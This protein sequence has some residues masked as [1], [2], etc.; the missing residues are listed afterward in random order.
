MTRFAIIGPT[1]PYRGGIAHHTTLLAQALAEQHEVLL[2]SFSQQYP[3]WLFPG[4]SDRDPSQRPLQTN[5]HYLLDPIN[6]FTW[7]RT[8]RQV[9]AWQPEVLILPWWHPYFAPAWGILGRWLKRLPSRPKLLFVCHNILPHEQSRL[10]RWVLPPLVRWT[11]ACGDGFVLQSH[12]E[13]AVL[14]TLL[15][16]R[17]SR[18]TPLPT[19]ADIGESTAPELP[20]PLPTEQPLLLFA[21]LVRPYKGVD[22]LLEAMALVQEPCHLLVAGEFWQGTERFAAQIARLGLADKVTLWDEYLPN[23]LL[24]ACL[25]RAD[26]LVLPY[27]SATQSAIVQLAFGQNKPVITTDVG[28]LGEVVVNGR[29]GLVVPPENP[30]ALAAA[31][32]TYLSQNLKPLFTANIQASQAQFSWQAFIAQLESLLAT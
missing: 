13:W 17:P 16:Q 6:P 1:Y 9:A 18:V 8:V 22:I 25:Q 29:T 24:A 31:I 4:K 30:A 12:T 32:D 3:R 28:G 2:M 20:M 15:P 19:Y 27:R 10:S 11:L 21:G 23:E 7:P 5:A 14:Q 26:V